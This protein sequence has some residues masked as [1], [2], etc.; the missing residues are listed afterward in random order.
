MHTACKFKLAKI[1]NNGQILF[2]QTLFVGKTPKGILGDDLQQ[3]EYVAEFQFWDRR[4]D[5]FPDLNQCRS[6]ICPLFSIFAEVI[7][8]RMLRAL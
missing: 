1:E 7:E 8:I 4:L 5:S 6:S 3:M 2:D